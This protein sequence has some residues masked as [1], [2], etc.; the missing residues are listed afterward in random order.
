MSQGYRKTLSEAPGP[1]RPVG[2][3]NKAKIMSERPVDAANKGGNHVRA[4]GERSE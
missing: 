3:A 4:A 2:A 1:E